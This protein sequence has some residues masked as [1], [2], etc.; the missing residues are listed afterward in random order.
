MYP[1]GAQQGALDVQSFRD[2]TQL[3]I[4]NTSERAF[5]PSR[6][7]INQ[8]YSREIDGLGVGQKITL[9]LYTF[10]DR[11]GTAFRAGGFFATDRP[12]RVALLQ[13]EE[14]GA[15]TGLISVGQTE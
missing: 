14:T 13:I 10:K 6:L 7:W 9:D 8:W 3:A 1:A 5:G 4:I 2:E 15:T 11:Y 12:D